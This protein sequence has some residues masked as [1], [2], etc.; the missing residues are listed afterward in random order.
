MERKRDR[1]EIDSENYKKGTCFICL[2]SRTFFC[3]SFTTQN[4]PKKPDSLR[5]CLHATLF[6]FFW[7]CS[8]LF[9]VFW[10]W[11]LISHLT[12]AHPVASHQPS[13]ATILPRLR[14][15]RPAERL[16]YFPE[17]FLLF[18]NLRPCLQNS[19]ISWRHHKLWVTL[20]SGLLSVQGSVHK[21]YC[22]TWALHV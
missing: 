2:S 14:A 17:H 15:V 9:S 4:P 16:G 19:R 11:L 5:R 7:C 22:T 12:A 3:M 13:E 10:C 1:E 21:Q 20:W 8:F 18:G 6:V